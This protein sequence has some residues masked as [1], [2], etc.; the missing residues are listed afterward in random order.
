MR[1]AGCRTS[2]EDVTVTPDGVVVLRNVTTVLEDGAVRLELDGE[3]MRM[4]HSE[5]N[6]WW[7]ESERTQA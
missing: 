5:I 2:Q 7:G 6:A 1:C 3:Q 4:L